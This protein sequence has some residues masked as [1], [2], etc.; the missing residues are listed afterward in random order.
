MEYEEGFDV[1][2][3]RD[4]Y[5]HAQDVEEAIESHIKAGRSGPHEWF[6]LVNF[7]KKDQERWNPNQR[8]DDPRVYEGLEDP[9]PWRVVNHYRYI[10]RP[11]KPHSIMSCLAQIWPDGNQSLTTHELRA[12]VNMMLLRVNHKPFR[13]CHIHPI[14]VLSYMGGHHGRIIQASYDGKG[15]IL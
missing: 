14:L 8:E 1:P 5:M 3:E 4:S 7:R 2:P 15:L 11:L 9:K 13:R 10:S 6:S 12:I